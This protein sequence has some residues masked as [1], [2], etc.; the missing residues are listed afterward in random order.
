M[1]DLTVIGILSYLLIWF[2][3][4]LVGSGCS[5][6]PIPTEPVPPVPP[7]T[8]VVVDTLTVFV[9]C[10]TVDLTVQFTVIGDQSAPNEHAYY[11]NGVEVG[12]YIVSETYA[13]PTELTFDVVFAGVTF[14]DVITI[15]LISGSRADA[16]GSS[17][18]D[19]KCTE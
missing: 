18:I 16:I 4:V 3:V 13:E 19:I 6:H 2:I 8:V 15:R 7:D 10:D 14:G 17:I 9:I 5:R 1:K 12:R 11:L